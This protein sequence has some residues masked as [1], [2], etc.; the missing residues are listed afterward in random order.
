MTENQILNAVSVINAYKEAKS[1]L[2]ANLE[3]AEASFLTEIKLRLKALGYTWDNVDYFSLSETEVSGQLS[4]IYSGENEYYHFKFPIEW[5]WAEDWKEKVKLFIIEQK[6]KQE[7]EDKEQ[8]EAAE[9]VVYERLK[10]KYS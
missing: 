2:E 8:V 6:R 3:M 7:L 5:L 1:K 4:E 10:K 9:R